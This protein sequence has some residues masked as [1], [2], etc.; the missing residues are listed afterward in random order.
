ERRG[1][2]YDR[3]GVLLAATLQVRSL[4]ADPA[5]ILDV[6]EAVAKIRE[7]FP[8]LSSRKLT[9]ILRDDKR[10]FV[11]LKRRISP[12]K[13]QAILALGVPGLGF[14][15]EYVRVYPHKSLASHILGSV[16]VDNIGLAGVERSFNTV[17]RRGEDVRLAVDVRAQEILRTAVQEQMDAS[18]AKAGW[19]IVMDITNGELIALT[20]LPD[21]D[22]NHFGEAT[23]N[24]RFNR[25][26]LG[27]YEMG[28]TFK[29]FTLAEGIDEGHIT[30]DT[31]IDARTPISI[32]KYTIRDYHAKKTILSAR[33]VLR[34]S[35]NI[36]AAKIADMSGPEHQKAF[37]DKLGMLTSI[38]AGIA[39]KG[40]VLYPS[41]WGRIQTFTISFGHGIAVTPLHMVAAV[42]ALADGVYRTPSVLLG[43][44]PVP[45]RELFKPDVVAKIRDLM[46]DVVEKGSGGRSKVPGYDIGGKTGTAEKASGRGYDTTRNLVS[47]VGVVPMEAPRYAVLVMLDEPKHGYHTGGLSAAP[48]VG[49]FMREFM[50][51]AGLRP[52]YDTLLAWQRDEIKKKKREV[53]GVFEDV[54]VPPEK[55]VQ[56]ELPLGQNEIF[57]EGVAPT[58]EGIIWNE[59]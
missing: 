4:Y 17:L 23:D 21:F 13:A 12:A 28:S 6:T 42:G 41:N 57:E 20:S 46:R 52:D 7:V 14:R 22:P 50:V 47:F 9:K 25:V 44:S 2:L 49:A 11:W 35:S 53:P 56:R 26:T 32:G 51:W 18:E 36:G 15:N 37:M 3:N 54:Y 27:S 59:Q 34:Y 58:I 24:Q 55:P 33:E 8:E 43:G 10:R 5:K 16:N 48:A 45:P 38:D 40:N 29:L 19:G 39:E 31:L 1:N 30:P